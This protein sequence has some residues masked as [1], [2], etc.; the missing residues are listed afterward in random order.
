MKLKVCKHT[1]EEKELNF[2]EGMYLEDATIYE[3]EDHG[4]GTEIDRRL[5]GGV[6]FLSL[7]IILVLED[8]EDGWDYGT[9][10][11]LKDISHL[12]KVRQASE[13]EI[14][15][16][17]DLINFK[18][19]IICSEVFDD[20]LKFIGSHSNDEILP[21]KYR[22]FEDKCELIHATSLASTIR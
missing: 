13:D 11:Y 3:E 1:F 19:L 17:L 14:K 10:Y 2:E 15:K 16:S 20:T 6:V 22:K 9:Y 4:Q 5:I 8:D 18:K 12:G 21:I 7:G